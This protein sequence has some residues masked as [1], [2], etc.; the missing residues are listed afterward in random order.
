[1]NTTGHEP[2]AP[3]NPIDA[4][5]LL[6]TRI[7][8]KEGVELDPDRLGAIGNGAGRKANSDVRSHPFRL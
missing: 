7:L 5:Y 3:E 1:M 4:I 8:E 6:L 2:F